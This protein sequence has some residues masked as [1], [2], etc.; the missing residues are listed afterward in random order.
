MYNTFLMSKDF[1]NIDNIISLALVNSLSEKFSDKI[2]ELNISSR[3][4]CELIGIESRTLTGILTGTLTKLDFKSLIKLCE[5]LGIDE[6]L[7]FQLFLR[8]VKNK[9]QNELNTVKRNKFIVENFDLANLKKSGFINSIKN[10]DE[11]EKRIND[12]FGFNS[13]YEYQKL[14]ITPAFSSTSRTKSDAQINFWINSAIKHF[15]RI[16]N[17]N[18]YNKEVLINLIPSFR[19]WSMELGEGLLKVSQSLYN[20]GVTLLFQSSLPGLQIK[21]ATLPVNSKPCIVLSDFNKSYALIWFSLLHEIFHVLCDW[22]AISENKYWLSLEGDTDEREIDADNF[23]T[24]YL[25]P[26]NFENL[27]HTNYNDHFF[28]EQLSRKNKIHPSIILSVYGYNH[29]RD[30]TN[31]WIQV[32]K[33][34]PQLNDFRKLIHLNNW[35][36]PIPIIQN[37]INIKNKLN[38]KN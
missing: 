14:N 15:S 5:F 29:R 31:F 13:I 4:A 20:V 6:N 18:R 3:A 24:D 16:D 25:L 1:K 37:A 19:D 21:G 27:L 34:S 36:N 10:F 38:V 26:P 17:P 22:E 8:E 9:N 32:R 2:K 12:Y 33:K 35:E 28:I 7:G 23:A 11:A 30:D